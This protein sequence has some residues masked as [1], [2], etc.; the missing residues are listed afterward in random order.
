MAIDGL[1]PGFVRFP[2][3]VTPVYSSAERSPS[4]SPESVNQDGV[5]KQSVG[6]DTT[7]PTQSLGKG[8]FLYPVAPLAELKSSRRVSNVDTASSID[9]ELILREHPS[10][11]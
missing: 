1:S 7:Y 2:V 10:E 3:E 6:I 9:L 8:Q 5:Q 11:A 4:L